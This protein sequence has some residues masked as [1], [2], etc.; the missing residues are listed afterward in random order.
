[1][2]L[3]NSNGFASTNAAG[4]LLWRW[5][6]SNQY[7]SSSAYRFLCDPG[8]NDPLASILWKSQ[9]PKGFTFFYGSLRG[10]AT[11]SR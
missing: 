6:P 8:V 5:E 1:M 11:N 4:L 9:I 2:H 10:T 3:R 7:S